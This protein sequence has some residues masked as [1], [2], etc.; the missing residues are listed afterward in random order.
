VPPAGQPRSGIARAVR[1]LRALVDRLLPGT[2]ESRPLGNDPQPLPARDREAGDPVLSG[3]RLGDIRRSEVRNYVIHLQG[4]GYAPLGVVKALVPLKVMFATAVEDGVLISDATHSLIVNRRDDRQE[5]PVAKAMTRKEFAVVLEAVPGYWRLFF[6]FL[7][8]T[9]VRISEA[10]G[11]DWSDVQFGARPVLKVRRQY[12]RGTLSMLKTR[13]ARRDIPLPPGLARKLW[14]VRPE[15]RRSDIRDTH[16]HALSLPQ[17]VPG[18]RQ[19][20]QGHTAVVGFVPQLQALVREHAVRVGQEHS[21]GGDVAGARGPRIHVAD[22]RPSTRLRFGRG[23][24][25]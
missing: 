11:A 15:G 13:S 9:G 24:L 21:P 25:P 5:E 1:G 7:I 22:L 3:T 18:A 17:R 12:Y 2:H 19:R 14:A 16:G 4:K 23:G 8:A 20:N 6:E 10:L